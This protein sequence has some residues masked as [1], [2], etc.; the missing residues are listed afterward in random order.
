MIFSAKHQKATDAINRVFIRSKIF[1]RS[2]QRSMKGHSKCPFIKVLSVYRNFPLPVWSLKSR[3]FK[4]TTAKA[5][6]RWHHHLSPANRRTGR[7]PSA[8]SWFPQVTPMTSN[9]ALL[10]N[11]FL[12]LDHQEREEKRT[13]SSH[14]QHFKVNAS[15][16][17]C[18]LT[19]PARVTWLRDDGTMIRQKL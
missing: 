11:S 8:W 3:W 18:C 2:T 17:V 14:Q 13:S 10:P 6:A 9:P 1:P 4:N 16:S 15:S 12:A 5:S 19:G 7:S